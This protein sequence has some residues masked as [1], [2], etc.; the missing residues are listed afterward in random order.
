MTRLLAEGPAS[1]AAQ[2]VCRFCR[3]G[4]ISPATL[5]LGAVH[6]VE[7]AFPVTDG[8]HLA[9]VPRLEFAAALRAAGSRQRSWSRRTGCRAF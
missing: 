2:P 8:H 7:D 3:A 1:T 5:R 4:L 9:S 6:A